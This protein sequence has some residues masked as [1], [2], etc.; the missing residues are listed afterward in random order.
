MDRVVRGL[1]QILVRGMGV[2]IPLALLAPT[3]CLATSWF[4]L[5]PQEI[6]R[7]AERIVI[8]RVGRAHPSHLVGAGIVTSYDVEAIAYLRPEGGGPRR[9]RVSFPGGTWPDDPKK[10]GSQIHRDGV[11]PGPP[12]TRLLLF[13]DRYEG[14]LTPVGAPNG[15]WR[16]DDLVSPA[17]ERTRAIAAYVA[18]AQ[19]YPPSRLDPAGTRAGGPLL[20]ALVAAAL[21]IRRT[22]KR[23]P[24]G[25]PLEGTFTP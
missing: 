22:R 9:F 4:Q 12:G 24:G 14:E 7:K 3:A 21:W 18:K 19:R 5:D 11:E 25:G 6:V 23:R 15:V 16:L 10:Y 17:D 13:L 8:A 20:G 2:A 1:R